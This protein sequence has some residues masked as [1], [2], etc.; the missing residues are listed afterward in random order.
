MSWFDRNVHWVLLTCFV[1]TTLAVAGVVGVGALALLAGL[2]GGASLG[3]LLAD[4]AAV[5]AVAVALLA[6]DLV[7]ATAF[8]V[9][10]VRKASLPRSERLAGFF[11]LVEGLIPPVRLLALSDR[12]EPS[13]EERRREIKRRYV[14]GELS[15]RGF[16]RE[17]AELL[18]ETEPE[19]LTVEPVGPVERADD[20]P[21]PGESATDD[22]ASARDG[23]LDERRETERE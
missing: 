9:T 23:P 13:V 20:A 21:G 4:A 14:D 22:T 1:A 19:P 18:D 12:F 17:M 3:A 15:E 8:V 11:G 2:L 7:L 10:V 16:E 5:L 6:A